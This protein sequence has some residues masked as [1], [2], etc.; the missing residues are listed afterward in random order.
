MRKTLISLIAFALLLAACAP[1]PQPVT[2]PTPEPTKTPTPVPPIPTPTRVELTGSILIDGSSTVYPI[3]EAMAEEFQKKH[4]GVRITVG[5]S[6]TGG[7]FKKFC[8]REIDIA[9][10]SRPIKSSEMEQCQKNGVEYIELP[11]AYD[12]LAVVVNPQNDWVDYMTVEELKKIWEPD[13]QG[14]IT[15]WNHVRPNWPNKP[16]N[17]YGPGVDSGTYDYFTEAIVGK[18]GSSRGDFL[19]SEDDNVLVHGV[20]TD[21]LALGYFGLA[22]YEENKDKLKI[23]PIDDGNPDN[24]AGPITP[25]METVSKGTYQPLSRPLFI[26]ISKAAADRP[27]VK[28]FVRFYLDYQNA[29][30]LIKE[31]GYIPLPAEVYK[32]A[33]ERFEKG[34]TGS[35]FGGK[36][37][38]PGITLEELLKR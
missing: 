11:I 28:A 23:V 22:Y 36:G 3:S 2:T 16:I 26:Y 1:A 35:I 4:P 8:N 29:G 19:A 14:K 38:Q 7:G 10:A 15:H 6:G 34:K 27:E 13:A 18:S 32:L 30:T 17:L 37:A 33:L 31:V 20:A 21:P 12:G 9:D 5:I 25:T 24:G